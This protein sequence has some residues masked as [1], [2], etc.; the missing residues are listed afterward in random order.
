MKNL[1]YVVLSKK[2][3]FFMI[4]SQKLDKHFDSWEQNLWPILYDIAASLVATQLKWL[5]NV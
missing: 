2:S 1:K 4:L 5:K 3:T